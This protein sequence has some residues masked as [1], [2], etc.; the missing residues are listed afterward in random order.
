MMKMAKGIRM[1]EMDYDWTFTRSVRLGQ[2][3]DTGLSHAVGNF[4][5]LGPVRSHAVGNLPSLGPA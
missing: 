5:S 2:Y 1:M 4:P 3:Q